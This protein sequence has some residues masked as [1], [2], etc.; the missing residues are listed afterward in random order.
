M[1]VKSFSIGQTVSCEFAFYWFQK[2]LE[3]HTHSIFEDEYK[4]YAEF[5]L[6]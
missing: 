1:F 5:M 6:I 2:V 3:Y 4:K